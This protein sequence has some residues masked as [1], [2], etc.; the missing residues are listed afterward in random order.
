MWQAIWKIIATVGYMFWAFSIEDGWVP[1]VSEG[2]YPTERIVVILL[3]ALVMMYQ[4]P[5]E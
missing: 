2:Q 4:R 5:K 1:F 3:Y